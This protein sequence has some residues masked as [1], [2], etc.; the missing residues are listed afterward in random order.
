M[1]RRLA[2]QETEAGS[3][4]LAL[5]QKRPRSRSASAV[6]R[7]SRPS[8]SVSASADFCPFLKWAGG[9]RKL[10]PVLLHHLP[11]TFSAYHEPM[12]GGGAL[13]FAL[14]T[15]YRTMPM[16]LSDVNV[17]LICAYVGVRDQADRLL[18]YLSAYPVSEEYYGKLVAMDPDHMRPLARAAR[19]LYLN[20][21]A[22][23]GLFRVNRSGRFNVPWGKYKDPLAALQGLLPQA[24]QA[25]QGV[26]VQV[27][28]VL[29][30]LQRAK[31]GEL[32]YLDPPYHETFTNYA[33]GAFT[34]R[35]QE[36]LAEAVRAAAER[37][38]LVMV[39][40]NATPF[41]KRLYSGFRMKRVMAPRSRLSC[42]GDQRGTVT[43]E[44]LIRT[45]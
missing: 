14:R 32:V 37:G 6:T 11:R 8:V 23:N 2:Q 22:Y 33:S 25:L 36:R 20:R 16:Y 43:A 45:W 10:L 13:F 12:V 17:D 21:C 4:S 31:A 7:L 19:T 30:A 18:E 27:Q 26:D 42:K 40:N 41:I 5:A 1:Q 15:Q 3:T 39:S 44:L 24:A 38:V 35:H 34:E 9:K 28:D 29:A